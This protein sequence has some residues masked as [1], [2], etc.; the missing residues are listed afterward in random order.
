[1][2]TLTQKCSTQTVLVVHVQGL[3]VCLVPART[4]ATSNTDKSRRIICEN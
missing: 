3:Y 2:S 4:T 1:M